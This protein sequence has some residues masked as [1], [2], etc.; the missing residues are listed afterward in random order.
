M[1]QTRKITTALKKL[2]KQRKITYARVADH[3]NL[4]EASIK[5]LFSQGGMTLERLEQ[6]CV[7]AGADIADVIAMGE[8]KPLT[9]SRLTPEQERELVADPKLLLVTL[10]IM[11]FWALDQIVEAYDLSEAETIGKLLQLERLG[12]IE[13]LPGNRVK[14]LVA[15]H[16]SWQPAGPVQR[17]FENQIRS[18]FL[19]SDFSGVGEQL[20]FVGGMLSRDSLTRMQMEID[21]LVAKMDELIQKDSELPLEEKYGAAAVLAM[22]PWEMP[23]FSPYRLRPRRQPS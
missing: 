8:Q 4:S 20:R 11:N 9:I 23:A 12:M 17:Y 13:L 10:L 19:A 2:L 21:D 7:L 14:R 15:R 1:Q 3:L 6:I 22:R 5:R 18:D 16:F